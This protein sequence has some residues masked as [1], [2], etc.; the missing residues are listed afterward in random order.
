MQAIINISGKQFTVTNGCR[1]KVPTQSSDIGKEINF[2][3]V[4]LVDDGEKVTVGTPTVK[5]ATVTATVLEHGRDRKILVYKK[6]RRK[7]YQRKNGHR[8]G[9][10]LLEVNTI[11]TKA[12][13][14][15]A[16][17]KPKVEETKDK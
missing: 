11:Q 12:A 15:K 17:A 14:K 7:G 13:T 2:E 9:Y 8:Q 3:E 10:T 4:L 1:V 6:K 5:N 16:P